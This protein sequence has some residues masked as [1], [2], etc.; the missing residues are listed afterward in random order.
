MLDVLEMLEAIF[1]QILIA[2]LELLFHHVDVVQTQNLN[3]TILQCLSG[4]L[5]EERIHL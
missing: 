4:E 1:K 2:I 5:A 3:F